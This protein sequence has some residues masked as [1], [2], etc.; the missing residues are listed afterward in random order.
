M[1]LY[2]GGI[3]LV[4]AVILGLLA[5]KVIV[6][7]RM[8]S[9]GVKIGHPAA[10]S[11][12]AKS[13]DAEF[14][15]AKFEAFRNRLA[16]EN[17]LRASAFQSLTVMLLVVGAGVTVTQLSQNSSATREQIAATQ[18]Q[19][20]LAQGS[21]NDTQFTQAVG[22]LASTG[23]TNQPT[24][25]GG[26]YSLTQLGVNAPEYRAKVIQV[27]TVY[28][29]QFVPRLTAAQAPP[30]GPLDAREPSLQAALT[31]LG[32][33]LANRTDGHIL[34]LSLDTPD[35]QSLYF[36]GAKFRGYFARTD[37]KLDALEGADFRTADLRGACLRGS[38][39]EEADFRGADLRG[40]DLRDIGDLAKA[41][42]DRQTLHDTGTRWPEG[43]KAGD[44]GLDSPS[45]AGGIPTAPCQE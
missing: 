11:E 4:G 22:Q 9:A 42:F 7:R 20:Q 8:R 39:A 32:G 17:D 12:D 18:Q 36:G 38:S 34:Q 10:K 3:V 19:I 16:A 28:V 41:K 21:E 44:F 24:R 35:G 29:Q 5:P 25:L 43:S 30:V 13:E 1:Y 37:F 2:L 45:P 31:S 33:D 40:A 27:L 15:A 14:E 23:R 26:V 6:G